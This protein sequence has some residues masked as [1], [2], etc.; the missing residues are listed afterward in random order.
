MGSGL[1]ITYASATFA[2]DEDTKA[3]VANSTGDPLEI[4]I[5]PSEACPT[6]AFT[7]TSYEGE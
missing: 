3:V 4:V 5:T 7:V 1:C 2:H 6:G